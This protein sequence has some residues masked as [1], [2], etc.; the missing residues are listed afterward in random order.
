MKILEIPF[1]YDAEIVPP[2]M[3]RPRAVQVVGTVPA[4][5][6]ELSAAQAPAVASCRPGRGEL[7]IDRPRSAWQDVVY[8]SAGGT[9]MRPYSPGM[10]H[11]FRRAGET[12]R[13]DE[14]AADFKA[15]I[16][17]AADSP[18]APWNLIPSPGWRGVWEDG[19]RPRPATPA[20][21]W[22]RDNRAERE[23]QVRRAVECG[24]AFVDGEFH[25]PSMGPAW[26]VTAEGVMA[27]PE[28]GRTAGRDTVVRGDRRA[29]ALAHCSTLRAM[30]WRPEGRGAVAADGEIEVA[31]P[32]ALSF[33]DDMAEG[34]KGLAERQCNLMR[35]AVGDLPP[36]AIAA[37]A[38]LKAAAGAPAPADGEAEALLEKACF[39]EREYLRHGE[40]VLDAVASFPWASAFS[41][42][43]RSVA[44]GLD[45]M[46]PPAPAPGLR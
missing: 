23:A 37:Y 25:V 1:C 14:V 46:A 30:S 9:L 10:A 42:L 7:P 16:R 19:A 8:R 45:G 15:W 36:R 31:D 39:L 44:S 21:E 24:S 11:P 18:P 26:I 2:G 28:Y 29:A 22:L 32:G 5:I 4:R 41:A 43:S 34:L 6:R 27:A 35:R 13:A 3:R 40:G 17:K 20:R 12:A 38:D 33:L